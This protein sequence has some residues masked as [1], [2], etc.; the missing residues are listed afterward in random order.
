[1]VSTITLEAKPY[2]YQVQIP[3]YGLFTVRCLGAGTQADLADKLHAAEKAQQKVERDFAEVIA[4]EKRLA[5]GGDHEALVAFRAADEYKH[6]TRAQ[7]QAT[8]VLQSASEAV[9]KAEMA[10][11]SSEDP[12]ALEKLMSEL[13]IEQ[14]RGLYRKVMQKVGETGGGE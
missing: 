14:I 2:E 12:K 7:A 1:M 4:E 9:V 8:T 5:E 10:L 13:T 6:A 3:G 11:W